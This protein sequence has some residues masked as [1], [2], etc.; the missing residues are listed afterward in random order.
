MFLVKRPLYKLCQMFPEAASNSMKFVLRDAAHDMEEMIEVKGR[1]AFP[2][3]DL[4]INMFCF[5][6]LL[7][8]PPPPP[9]MK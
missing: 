7:P 5:E 4:V 3:L 1:A 6:S 2:G 8:P 9:H